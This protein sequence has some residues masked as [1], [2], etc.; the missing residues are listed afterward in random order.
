MGILNEGF[1]ALRV[2]RC[3][4]YLLMKGEQVLYV[5]QSKGVY[6]RITAH[7]HARD[8][9][10]VSRVMPRGATLQDTRLV[11]I[12]FDRVMVKWCA[13]RELRHLEYKYIQRFRPPYNR[14]VRKPLHEFDIE[15]LAAEAGLDLDNIETRDPFRR[16]FAA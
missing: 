11:P 10:C 4:V 2:A 3:G 16:R 15:V 14:D 12:P 6:G 8:K 7:M 9:S 1:T 5:G 13:E